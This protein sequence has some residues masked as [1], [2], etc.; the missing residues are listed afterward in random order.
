[1]FSE[2]DLTRFLNIILRTHDELGYRQEQ[3][4]HLELGMLKMVH[5]HRLLPL[6]E[7]L[8]QM[9]AGISAVPASGA[10]SARKPEPRSIPAASAPASQSAG[11]P[12]VS[13]FEADRARKAGTSEPKLVD[14]TKTP[15]ALERP[16]SGY[17]Y[18]A[19]NAAVAV[20]LAEPEESGNPE[21]GAVSIESLREFLMS[22]LEEQNQHTAAD[23][24]AR[25]EWKLD[26]NQIHL[27]LPIAEKVI[28]ISLSSEARKLLT[29]EAS[30]RC[31]RVMKLSISGG[32]SGNGL[33][34]SANGASALGR[35]NASWPQSAGGPLSS[36]TESTNSG[37]GSAR[38]R[39]LADPIVKRM[40]E[41]FGAEVRSVIDHRQVKK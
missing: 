34:Q 32:G 20:A 18:A 1:L 12:A 30:R 26:G 21:S 5:A 11:R 37:G 16:S 7:L 39:A 14:S 9:P 10:T 4:F 19:T 33:S 35:Q 2:E 41:K 15:F 38:Q 40:Q 13:P 23:L 31:G 27:R 24:L 3:R 28:D 17:S 29:Q 8:S 6:E 25:G 36:G 22:T